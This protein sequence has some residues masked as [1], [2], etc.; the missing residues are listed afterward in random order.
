MSLLEFKNTVEL[1]SFLHRF[2]GRAKTVVF[3]I[4]MI[5]SALLSRWYVIAT[6]WLFYLLLFFSAGIRI[7]KLIKRLSIPM[8]MALI[9]FV[10]VIFTNGNHIFYSINI[11]G[12][13]L[14]IYSEGISLGIIIALRVITA[15]TIGYLLVFTT[16]MT[17]ILETL[18]MLKIPN[19]I[20]D[21]ANMMYRYVFIIEEVKNSMHRAQISRMGQNT[22]IYRRLIDSGKTAAYV[23]MKALDKSV[24]I[25]KA[26]LSRGYSSETKRF[27]FFNEGIHKRDLIFIILSLIFIVLCVIG[28][29]M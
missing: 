24:N 17:E 15:A 21:I 18:R 5:T 16:P 22:S 25:Y 29:Q 9:V 8:V 14:D 23:L 2:D 10:N 1:E 20:I 19:T 13:K 28:N 7:N 12:F 3:L 27:A 26:M 6:M 4:S 11:A